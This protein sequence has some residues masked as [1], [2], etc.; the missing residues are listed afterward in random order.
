[1]RSSQGLASV[2][3]VYDRAVAQHNK[4]SQKNGDQGNK[5]RRGCRL[6][7]GRD[8]KYLLTKARFQFSRS[9]RFSSSHLLLAAPPSS[10]PQPTLPN[11]AK[12]T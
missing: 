2:V 7:K 1:M 5:R 3:V 6:E 12:D 11:R 9:P 4:T 10:H 8:Q